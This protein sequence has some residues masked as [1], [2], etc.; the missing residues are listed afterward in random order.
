M[1]TTVAVYGTRAHWAREVSGQVRDQMWLAHRLR[2]DLVEATRRR[3]DTVAAVWSAHPEIAELEVRIAELTERAETLGAQAA[4]GR[5]AA[6]SRRVESPVADE[7]RAVRAERRQ[8]KAARREAIQAVRGQEGDRIAAAHTA[9]RAE[10]KALYAV[11]CQSGFLLDEAS[12]GPVR[13]YWAVFN[14]VVRHHRTACERIAAARAAGRPAQLRHH[15]WQGAAT[16]AVQLQHGAGDPPATAQLLASGEGK[17]R[18]VLQLRPGP[19]GSV[20]GTARMRIGPSCVDIPVTLHRSLPAGADVSGAELVVRRVGSDTRAAVHV[21]CR[22]PDPAPR[23]PQGRPVIAVHLGWRRERGGGIRVATWRASMPVTVPSSGPVAQ[24]VRAD[25]DRTGTIVLPAAWSARLAAADG[26]R[27]ER[28]RR[29]NLARDALVGHLREVPPVE[30]DGWPSAVD[31]ARWRSPA[32]FAA[33]AIRHRDA[34]P[35]GREAALADLERWRVWDKRRW[36]AEAHGR[37]GVIGRR[38]DA[39]AVAAAWVTRVAGRVVVD[40][41]SVAEV[42]PRSAPGLD[43][44]PTAMEAAAGSQR[45]HA[46]PGWLRGRLRATCAREGVEV[47]TVPHEGITRTHYRC[48][49]VNPADHD[50]TRRLVACLGCGAQYDQDRSAT[51]MVLAASGTVPGPGSGTA[52]DTG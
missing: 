19:D 12:P 40:D 26:H 7:L 17:W 20:R 15:R 23:D 11:Y 18:N 44:A 6:R 21:T 3:E 24:V 4:R 30:G 29:L 33:L 13:L 31:V 38:R 16:L 42:A 39:Y 2:E 9:E 41:M 45:V 28:D 50:Y 35:P 51:L 47:V 46:A 34:P 27:S 37:D 8:S 10:V 36:N 22:V 25:T 32:R 14:Q 5:S 1:S 52:R 49:H 43:A 48:G